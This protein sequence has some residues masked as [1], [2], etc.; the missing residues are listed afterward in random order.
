MRHVQPCDAFQVGQAHLREGDAAVPQYEALD[1]LEVRQRSVRDSG[2]GA[3]PH[4]QRVNALEVRKRRHSASSVWPM[5]PARVMRGIGGALNVLQV[6]VVVEV[7]APASEA[8]PGGLWSPAPL[9]L[10]LQ[11]CPR[12]TKREW[13]LREKQ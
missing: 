4:D 9:P 2:L 1:A 7:G 10:A 5:P 8:Q 3:V 11:H 12:C 6:F 13:T